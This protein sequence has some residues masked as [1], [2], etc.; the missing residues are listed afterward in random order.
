[1]FPHGHSPSAGTPHHWNPQE[2]LRRPLRSPQMSFIPVQLS[3]SFGPLLTIPSQDQSYRTQVFPLNGLIRYFLKDC[4]LT[5]VFF[6]SK[7]FAAFCSHKRSLRIVRERKLKHE[8]A[9]LRLNTKSGDGW[10]E[11][12]RA[13]LCT[14]APQPSVKVAKVPA[15]KR[16]V[17]NFPFQ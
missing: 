2:S 1:M 17:L 10:M 14:P 11:T 12:N 6:C 8:N 13:E 15:E 7:I 5:Q 3:P 4:L 16:Q 9:S